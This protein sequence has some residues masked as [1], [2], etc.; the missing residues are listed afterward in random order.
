MP[1]EVFA[2]SVASQ[3]RAKPCGGL[4]ASSRGAGTGVLESLAGI[5]EH[6]VV[7]L[8]GLEGMIDAD[9]HRVALRR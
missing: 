3:A 5:L 9:R 2:C 1:F 4:G 7:M 6:A 8:G